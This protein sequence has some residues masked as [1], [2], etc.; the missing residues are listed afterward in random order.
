MQDRVHAGSS[1]ACAL[2][3]RRQFLA[4]MSCPRAWFDGAGRS[5]ECLGGNLLHPR[6]FRPCTLCS[7]PRPACDRWWA[8]AAAA[9]VPACAGMP[10][11]MRGTLMLD[12]GKSAQACFSLCV[13]CAA[14]PT[15]LFLHFSPQAALPTA[16]SS[17]A[18]EQCSVQPALYLP[19]ARLQWLGAISN[20]APPAPHCPGS[21]NSLL[22]ACLGACSGQ[23]ACPV[24]FLARQESGDCLKVAS[25]HVGPR[26]NHSCDPARCGSFAGADRCVAPERKE[27]IPADLFKVTCPAGRA[28][29]MQTLG[30]CCHA[31]TLPRCRL[32]LPR[33]PR[34][35]GHAK[36][37]VQ[38]CAALRRGL[39]KQ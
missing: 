28:A 35:H 23:V 19:E 16:S 6:L 13:G 33:G 3:G 17:C 7:V 39:C 27:P 15:D 14:A 25:W 4:S 26:A 36:R 24:P 31:V 20:H 37:S 18:G 9:A 30:P 11:S 32:G 22:S 1:P 29:P 8:A 12:G 5:Q 2:E 10:S 38:R 34:C 21:R